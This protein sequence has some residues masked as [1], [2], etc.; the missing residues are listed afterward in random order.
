MQRLTSRLSTGLVVFVL[1]AAG[2][3]GAAAKP[4]FKVTIYDT[5]Y[6]AVEA[7]DVIGKV[8]VAAA[9]M[10]TT[11]AR[12]CPKAKAYVFY[13]GKE[14]GIVA[15]P[16]RNLLDCLT[17]DNGGGVSGGGPGGWCALQYTASTYRVAIAATSTRLCFRLTSQA[18]GGY[19]ATALSNIQD[20]G[21]TVITNGQAILVACQRWNGREL[22]DYVL[23]QSTAVPPADRQ[24][25]WIS[26][27]TVDTRGQAWLPGVPRC[28]S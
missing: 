18:P 23:T 5:T 26:D 13:A 22:E 10:A 17:S 24:G 7:R 16:P 15:Y 21:R 19:P 3:E 2:A 9:Q 12:Y 27:S 1:C 14:A 4:I 11:V 8:P 28:S 6:Y 25:Y 20:R